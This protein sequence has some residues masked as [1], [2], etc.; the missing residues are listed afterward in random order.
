MF[1]ECLIIKN[2][3]MNIR[4]SLLSF[5]VLTMSVYA[6]AQSARNPLNH[7]SARITLQKRVS[8]WN[9]SEE[10]FYRADG[11]PIDKRSFV[12]DNDGRRISNAVQRWKEGAWQN[13]SKNDYSSEGNKNII[14]TSV[15]NMT[16]WQNTTKV[17]NVYNSERKQI[18]SLSYSWD[19]SIDDWSLTPKLKCEWTYDQSGRMTEYLKKRIDKMANEWSVDARILYSYDEKGNF[20][21]ELYQSWVA[22]SESWINKGKYTYSNDSETQKTAISYY[23]VSDE[24]ILDGKIIY[25][26]DIEGKLT[27]SEYY[28]NKPDES[29]GAYSLYT[30]SEN[31]GVFISETADINVYPN[32]VISSFELSVPESLVGKTAGI[33]DI[34]G[35]FV[36]SVVVNSEKTQVNVSGI[37]GGIYVLKIGDKTKK[38][39]IK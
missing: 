2:V 39:I 21:E 32:P 1:S 25:L 9:L 4:I 24:W 29:L 35:S 5:V 18:Y 13:S 38:F 15:E 36:K 23:Y 31:R 10:T 20:S 3:N 37:S 22:D 6:G 8:T 28:G 33:F 7:E 34:Y 26:Y 16:G 19:N 30:Y 27:R 12:Y 17:E 11:T 14:I